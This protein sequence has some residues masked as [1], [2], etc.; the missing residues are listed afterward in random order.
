MAEFDS[1]YG[2]LNQ[3]NARLDF[4]Y[5]V[6]K[7]MPE[8]GRELANKPLKLL[9]LI[10]L[11]SP[12]WKTLLI[13]ETAIEYLLKIPHENLPYH[14]QKIPQ[15]L[16]ASFPLF[17]KSLYNWA[18]KYNLADEWLIKHF[19]EL[20][21][22]WVDYPQDKGKN[23]YSTLQ[24]SPNLISDDSRFPDGTPMGY[25]NKFRPWL[26]DIE[27]KSDY[28]KA[29]QTADKKSFDEYLKKME[30]FA[31]AHG[32]KRNQQ[33]RK[34]KRHLEWFIHYQVGG[35]TYREI[36]ELCQDKKGIDEA[37]II[38]AVH[39]IAKL[40]GINLREPSKSGRKRNT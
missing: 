15:T 20:L 37:A 21:C 7:L 40:L 25:E 30:N 29:Y 2:G 23:L 16:R 14:S 34:L 31:L 10:H 5:L 35:K 36:A 12:Q 3:W 32:N 4:L 8:V 13:Q 38:Q 39:N 26:Y 18:V 17:H 28:R 27:S 6:E 22:E 1:I 24:R 19:F 33:K 9:S 11:D